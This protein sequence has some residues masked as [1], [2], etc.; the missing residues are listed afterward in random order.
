MITTYK[1]D[2]YTVYTQV[3]SENKYIKKRQSCLILFIVSA[4]IFP[5]WFWFCFLLVVYASTAVPCDVALFLAS[6]LLRCRRWYLRFWNQFLICSSVISRPLANSVRSS[7]VR[8]CWLENIFSRYWSWRCVK[9]LRFLRFFFCTF[10]LKHFAVFD[11]WRCF[12][13]LVSSGKTKGKN[14]NNWN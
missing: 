3:S 9:W 5:F 14:V 1:I 10:S 7:R 2:L 4:N 8:Y 12:P 13:Q 11:S 6:S